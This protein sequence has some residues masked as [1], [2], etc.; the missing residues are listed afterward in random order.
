[1]GICT[2]SSRAQRQEEIVE[3]E[4]HPHVAS[5]VVVEVRL[6]DEVVIGNPD[7]PGV[8]PVE[9][10]DRMQ[11]R[12]LPATRRADDGDRLARLDLEVH[13]G[14]RPDPSI[15]VGLGRPRTRR[16]GYSWR[17][18]IDESRTAR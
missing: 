15:L 12:R 13:S 18:S 17:R 9:R 3:L 7:D 6:V 14:Q 4:D 10:G 8:R 11:K 16:A 5:A 1:M 2:F